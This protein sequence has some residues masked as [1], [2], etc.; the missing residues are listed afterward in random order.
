M[1][2]IEVEL[3]GKL[4]RVT[5]WPGTYGRQSERSDSSCC[6]L[7]GM[8]MSW[9]W[10]TLWTAAAAS[11]DFC[12]SG[13]PNWCMSQGCMISSWTLSFP[14]CATCHSH[15]TKTVM[16]AASLTHLSM[17]S[18]SCGICS[19]SFGAAQWKKKNISFKPFTSLPQE[20]FLQ[21]LVACTDL[22]SDD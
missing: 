2:Y 7:V 1:S 15:N 10:M 4:K 17:S 20:R 8:K 16:A 12:K 6:G 19:L 22:A 9:Q 18:H 3:Q 21:L 13:P 11:D 5:N 14:W